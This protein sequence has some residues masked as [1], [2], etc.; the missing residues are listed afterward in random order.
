MKNP[1][2]EVFFYKKAKITVQDLRKIQFSAYQQATQQE[3]KLFNIFYA[4]IKVVDV[5]GYEDNW[6]LP[7]LL[8][9]N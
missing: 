5:L 1:E 4:T 3:W 2:I 7:I 6:F 9:K 8:S